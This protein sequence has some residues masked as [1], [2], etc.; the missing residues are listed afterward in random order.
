MTE[1]G[2]PD[3]DPFAEA[4]FVASSLAC[5]LRHSRFGS[6]READPRQIAF[7]ELAQCLTNP[8]NAAGRQVL[9][10]ATQRPEIG[11]ALAALARRFALA[12]MPA[13]AAASDGT[14]PIRQAGDFLMRIESSLQVGGP[15]YLVI[16]GPAQGVMPGLVI[17]MPEA[18]NAVMHA[19]PESEDGTIQLL[20]EAKSALLQLLRDPDC[21]F[22]LA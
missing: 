10:V 20:L 21:R 14:Y 22:L 4:L 13:V 9:E 15:A 6:A 19:L 16:Q 3:A 1:T 11:S 12:D 8:G 17:G 18:E 7:S 2:S 5:D